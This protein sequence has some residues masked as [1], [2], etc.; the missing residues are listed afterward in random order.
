MNYSFAVSVHA[1]PTESATGVT[2]RLSGQDF[3]TLAIDPSRLARTPFEQSFE[4]TVEN[5]SRLPR[6]FTE[7]DGSFVWTSSQT[8]PPWQIDGNLFDRD[9]RLLFVD[10]KGSCPVEAMNQ[11]LS[12][13]GWPRTKFVFQLTRQAILLDEAEFRRAALAFAAGGHE[14]S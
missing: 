12:A 14:P 9:G 4:E 13:F 10:L 2:I 5:L 11:L 6:M 7:P 1:R 3:D 8:D